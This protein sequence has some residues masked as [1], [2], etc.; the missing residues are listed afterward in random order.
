M[1]IIVLAFVTVLTIIVLIFF[2]W[3]K[4]QLKKLNEYFCN[5]F[6]VYA[7]TNSRDAKLAALTAAM[8]ADKEQCHSML[9]NLHDITS[10]LLNTNVNDPDF[11]TFVEQFIFKA[12]ELEREISAKD[13]THSDIIS[14]K[15][16]LGKMNPE[17]LNALNKC[18]PQVFKRNYP[19]LF[20]LGNNA[21]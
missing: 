20:K 11:A 12:V 4:S 9:G 21:A 15:D 19:H 5:A 2:F 1:K 7:F 10:D 3:V 13:W 17:Y 18:D 6:K 14:Q 8:V 16:E